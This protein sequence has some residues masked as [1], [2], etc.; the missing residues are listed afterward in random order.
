MLSVVLA[1]IFVMLIDLL[2]SPSMHNIDLLISPSISSSSMW[3]KQEYT[4]GGPIHWLS[5][6]DHCGATT[7]RISS[8]DGPSSIHSTTLDSKE[9]ECM[10]NVGKDWINFCA[11]KSGRY[12]C[13][14]KI[15]SNFCYTNW[16]DF[17]GGHENWA[18]FCIK[19]IIKIDFCF[20]D[21][22]H[23]W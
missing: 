18:D 15:G 9:P 5:S 10:P 16:V 6:V 2:I 8:N 12:F 14:I 1:I 23:A 22:E 19:D 3:D 4:Y 7:P 17:C 11:L 13:A 21:P 20:L